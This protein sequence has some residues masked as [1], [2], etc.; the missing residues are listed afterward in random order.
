MT[1]STRARSSRWYDDVPPAT[2]EIPCGE[3]THRI[4]WRRGK[5]ILEDHP[6]LR[7]EEILAALGGDK[8]ACL[9]LLDGWRRSRSGFD[10]SVD[11]LWRGRF[12]GLPPA[13]RSRSL[14]AIFVHWERHWHEPEFRAS[15]GQQVTNQVERHAYDLLRR[16]IEDRRRVQRHGP[17]VTIQVDVVAARHEPTLAGHL[18]GKSSHVAAELGPRWLARVWMRGRALAQGAFVVDVLGNDRGEEPLAV[19]AARWQTRE[20]GSSVVVVE[21]AWLRTADNGDV[22]ITWQT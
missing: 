2:F 9:Q 5:L 18:D 22:A 21:D 6:D 10:H 11:N 3:E 19:R 13:Y 16:F 20:D 12:F 7:S 4:T 17:Q 15:R 1:N 14:L 8:Y